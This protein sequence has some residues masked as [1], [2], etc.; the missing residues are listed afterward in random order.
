[1][2]FWLAVSSPLVH[3][4]CGCN[5]EGSQAQDIEKFDV[6]VLIGVELLAKVLVCLLDLAVGGILLEAK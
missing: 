6:R 4:S 5:G 2:N 3:V 1:M